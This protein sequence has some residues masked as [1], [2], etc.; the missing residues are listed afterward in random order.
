MKT[1]IL[2]EP[3]ITRQL[4]LAGSQIPNAMAQPRSSGASG[5]RMPWWLTYQTPKP[6]TDHERC[7]V[8]GDYRDDAAAPYSATST[9]TRSARDG[10]ASAGPINPPIGGFIPAPG[11][12]A[13]G[14]PLPGTPE[15]D[16][17]QGW[18]HNALGGEPSLPLK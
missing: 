18:L 15:L 12:V 4:C 2:V 17:R 9:A 10:V 8:L 3:V 16:L 7:F 14:S 5:P 6:S 11:S 1:G 13:S